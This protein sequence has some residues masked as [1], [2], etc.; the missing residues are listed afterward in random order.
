M[1]SISRYELV[2][3]GVSCVVADALYNLGGV[4]EEL[5]KLDSAA[6]AHM[7]AANSGIISAMNNLAVL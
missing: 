7:Q 5:E 6:D 2:I 1:S 3:E 4:Y